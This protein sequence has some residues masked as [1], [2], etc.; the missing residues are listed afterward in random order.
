MRTSEL[1]AIL[2]LVGPPPIPGMAVL[3]V[4][5][6]APVDCSLTRPPIT[7]PQAPPEVSSGF[8]LGRPAT[9]AFPCAMNEV[10]IVPMT[11]LMALVAPTTPPIIG[12]K[13]VP[14][15]L[16]KV[17]VQPGCCGTDGSA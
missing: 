17:L 2:P 3:I 8:G 9:N 13:A 15:G 7:R 10:F 1:Q 11:E 16:V 5:L 6:K 14:T 4:P 12:E